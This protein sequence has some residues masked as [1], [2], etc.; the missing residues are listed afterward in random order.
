VYV[1][2]AIEIECVLELF[3]SNTLSRVTRCI[4]YSFQS[5]FPSSASSQGIVYVRFVLS[6]DGRKHCQ[7]SLYAHNIHKSAEFPL[8]GCL[9]L[10]VRSLRFCN[11]VNT[12]K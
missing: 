8:L 2:P 1:P 7:H 9:D 6:H 11:V 4:G 12:L 3:V 10:S 5:L